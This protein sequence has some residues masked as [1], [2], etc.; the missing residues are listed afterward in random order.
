MRTST[1]L[2]FAS[3][4]LLVAT[5]CKPNRPPQ[6]A[7][8]SRTTTTHHAPSAESSAPAE[9][10]QYPTIGTIERLALDTY[11]DPD[12]F[13]SY[14]RATHRGEPDYGRQISLIGLTG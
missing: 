5:S 4:A 14:R 10:G 7:R 12:R 9:G 1:L 3:I 13:F 6:T 2:A 11:A 8:S